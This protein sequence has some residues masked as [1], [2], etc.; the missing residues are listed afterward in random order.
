MNDGLAD[1]EKIPLSRRTFTLLGAGALLAL[2]FPNSAGAL[3]V[4]RFRA[5]SVLDRVDS[6]MGLIRRS[7]WD[8]TRPVFRRLAL[9]SLYSR[10]TI[11]HSGTEPIRATSRT[12]VV[13]EIAHIVRAHREKRFGDIA[14]H[15]VVDY[16]GRVWEGRSLAY[17]GAHVLSANHGNIGILALGNFERQYPSPAQLAGMRNLVD[18]LRT[19]CKIRRSKIFGH[20]DLSPSACPGQ[21]LYP[22]VATLRQTA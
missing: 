4:R 3:P 16:A 5:R 15:F 17:E 12:A 14:Y 19:T 11:H 6:T 22:Y 7:E 8:D 1:L 18:I 20:R 2:V 13:R 9:A 10:L 21:R